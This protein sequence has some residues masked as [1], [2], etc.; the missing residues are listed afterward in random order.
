MA[1]P[2]LPSSETAGN[3]YTAAKVNAIYDHLQWHRDTAPVFKGQAWKSNFGLV[4]TST[5]TTL[6]FGTGGSFEN[7]PIIN[8]GGWTVNAADADP[9]SLVVP[10]SGIYVVS[11]FNHWAANSSGVRST[12]IFLNGSGVSGGRV[13]G[14][15]ASTGVTMQNLTTVLDLAAND[16]LDVSLHQSSGSTL[17]ATVYLT[18][19]WI[20]ST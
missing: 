17:A 12:Q 13:I 6:G 3:V 10:E 4:S 14:P 15:P 20:R 1:V 7:A 2:A 18:A 8:V 11:V 19:H 9:E 16:E 5:T